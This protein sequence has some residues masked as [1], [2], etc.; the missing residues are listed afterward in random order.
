MEESWIW[1]AVALFGLVILSAFFS[2]SETALIGSGRVSLNL[3][4][5]KGSSGAKR[6][7]RLIKDP[8][9]LLGIILVG[10]NLVNVMAAALATVLLGP[11]YAT[12]LI[13]LVLLIF[14]EITPKTLA[15][16]KPERFAIR[17]AGLVQTFGLIFRPVVWVTTGIADLILWPVLGGK[18]QRERRMSRQ[19]LMTAIR[20]GAS[21]G[22]LEPSETRMTREVLALRDK[23]VQ[24]IMIPLNEVDAIDESAE[25][26]QV[27]RAF[28][29]TENTRYPVYRNEISEL[30]GLF[31]V[32]DLL[33][34]AEG[35]QENWLKY[36][37]PLMRCRAEL[38]ADELLRDMQIQRSHMAAV[39][40]ESGKVIGIVTMEDI[41]EEIVGEIQD[42][43]DDE[44]GDLIRENSPGRYAV[45]GKVEVDDL[46][47][48]INVDLGQVDQQMNLSEWFDR[49][50]RDAR[51]KVRRLKIGS[52]RIISRGHGRFEILV[53]GQVRQKQQQKTE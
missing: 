11:V 41:L 24:Q 25:Y 42:E 3:L 4:A 15:A 44:E 32:K 20:L 31:L 10:N 38:E 30:V 14:A 29:E 19:E 6:A 27:I 28:V 13:T 12:I 23:Q 43:Y 26:S 5:E 47:K 36:V 50:S 33:M 22:E 45:Q 34:H 35:I 46:C 52:A 53:K 40:D 37:R 39:E 7:L 17:I 9:E 49:R 16:Y 48:V 51:E 1:P 18:Q 8:G 21:D 2:G